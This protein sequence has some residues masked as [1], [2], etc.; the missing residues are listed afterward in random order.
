MN[1]ESLYEQYIATGRQPC[2]RGDPQRGIKIL[3]Y[4]DAKQKLFESLKDDYSAG[5]FRSAEADELVRTI[6]ES[7]QNPECFW[8]SSKISKSNQAVFLYEKNE[9][10]F[11]ELLRCWKEQRGNTMI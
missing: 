1:T 5:R 8:G 11:E 2:G 4:R 10:L 9:R 6:L 3:Q 7:T